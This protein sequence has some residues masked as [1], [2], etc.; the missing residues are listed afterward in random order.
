MKAN[1]Y[2]II[3]CDGKMERQQ[4]RGSRG[5]RRQAMSSI[6]PTWIRKVL[7]ELD[8]RRNAWERLR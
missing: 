3:D 7:S 4:S 6:D 5:Q 8:K 1:D 2:L